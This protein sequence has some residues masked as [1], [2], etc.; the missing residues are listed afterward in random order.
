MCSLDVDVT[1]TDFDDL[2]VSSGYFLEISQIRTSLQHHILA[3]VS[4]K[5][6]PLLTL[7]IVYKKQRE[8]K[9]SPVS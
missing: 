1:E 3:R 6:L 7:F 4:T 5:Q 9:T 8:I 2:K